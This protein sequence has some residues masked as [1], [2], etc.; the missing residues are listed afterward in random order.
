MAFHLVVIRE[1]CS[2]CRACQLACSQAHG[3]GFDPSRSRLFVRKD[4]V[5]GC[6][7]PVVCRS[8]VDAACVGA[9]PTAALT[10]TQQGWLSLD[11]ASCIKCGACVQACPHDA[12][13]LDP[14]SRTPLACDGCDGS[15]ACV[16]AC[17][18]GALEVRL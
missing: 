12:L 1:N 17:V 7:C 9:C 14:S 16:A 18:T 8:C 15:P 2:G 4:D 13:R 11:E 6:D 3:A 10:Q 5:A